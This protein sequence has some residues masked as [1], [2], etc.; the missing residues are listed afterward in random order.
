MRSDHRLMGKRTRVPSKAVSE[1][2]SS[3]VAKDAVKAIRDRFLGLH[4]VPA[5]NRAIGAISRL[6]PANAQ[7]AFDVASS[8]KDYRIRYRVRRL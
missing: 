5:E 8:D 4:G 6:H 2:P 3:A 1:R 7:G